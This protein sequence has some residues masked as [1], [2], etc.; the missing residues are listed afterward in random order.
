LLERGLNTEK[1][2]LLLSSRA[3][4]VAFT[5]L[6]NLHKHKLYAYVLSLTESVMLA[7]DIVQDVFMKLWYEHEG[8]ANIANFRS[9]LFRMSKN[10]V[11][12]QFRRM[13]HEALIISE[14]FQ[15]NTLHNHTENVV[16]LKETERLLAEIINKLPTQQ[17][18]VYRL[19]RE[20]GRS[21]EEIAA[22]LKISTH[23]VRNHI[24]QALSTIR[25][26][27]IQNSDTFM[28]LVFA[29]ALKY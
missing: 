1:T 13:S 6:F 17:K 22:I 11:I 15:E 16:F 25:R 26:Q 4:E 10:L 18:L 5:S 19:S 7:E 21:H 2:L 14:M 29:A 8:L 3:D 12:D 24:V 20:E 9:Y 27:L 28:L 23:T